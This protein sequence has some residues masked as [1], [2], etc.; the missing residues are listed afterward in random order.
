MIFARTNTTGLVL[1]CVSSPLLPSPY[2]LLSQQQPNP[3]L[4]AMSLPTERVGALG[5][6]LSHAA[7]R[8][9]CSGHS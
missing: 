8:M 3:G 4:G 7:L 1:D 2:A 6:E 5:D 9:R